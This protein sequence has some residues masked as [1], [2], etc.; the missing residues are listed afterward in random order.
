MGGRAQRIGTRVPFG[1]IDHTSGGV[2]ASQQ[3]ST[4]PTEDRDVDDV[5]RG[6]AVFFR[7]G[8]ALVRARVSASFLLSAKK[9]R[10]R[11]KT[12]DNRWGRVH[13]E[14]RQL[15]CRTPP[16][17]P[18]AVIRRIQR[19]KAWEVHRSSWDPLMT[20]RLLEQGRVHR[21]LAT[22]GITTSRWITRMS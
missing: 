8:R 1:G 11:M 6:V 13:Q 9:A 16:H 22:L 2:G 18:L 5:A 20:S 7:H 21:E 3:S 12:K 4:R 17:T 19:Y 15:F 10:Q 14:L